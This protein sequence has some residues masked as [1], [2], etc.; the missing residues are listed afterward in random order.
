MRHIYLALGIIFAGLGAI[1]AAL[2]IMPTVP[3][4]LVAV[5]F[6][7]RSSPKLEKRILDHP[8]FGPQVRDWQERRAISRKSKT[9]AIL[10]M[11]G[12]AVFTYFT[13]GHPYYWISIA[14]LVISGTW[15][16]TRNE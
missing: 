4:L 12:G 2:P 7:A 11:A 8:H 16:A 10:A 1:G 3:F 13:L 9:V 14:I 6:F 15:I 5:Y